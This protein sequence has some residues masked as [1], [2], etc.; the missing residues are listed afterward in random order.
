MKTERKK[1]LKKLMNKFNEETRFCSSTSMMCE[2]KNFLILK[3]IIQSTKNKKRLF[4]II[5]SQMKKNVFLF[6]LLELLTGQPTII[7]EEDRGKIIKI[8]EFWRQYQY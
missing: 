1:D 5:K 2:N 8:E 4:K 3:K 6:K 7:K